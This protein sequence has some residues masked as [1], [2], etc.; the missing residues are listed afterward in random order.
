MTTNQPETEIGGN[1]S[2]SEDN[3]VLTGKSRGTADVSTEGGLHAQFIRS[4]K[5]HAR[6]SIDATAAREHDGV[7]AVYTGEEI[8][9]SDTPTP[10]RFSLYGPPMRGLEYPDEA[11]LQ[12]TVPTEK[13]HYHG[14]IIGVVVAEQRRI[15]RDAVDKVEVSYD[16]LEPIMTTRD[17]IADDAPLIHESVSDNVVFEGTIGDK[18]QTGKLFKQAAH[19]AELKKDPQRV[20]P[21][22]MEPRS[23]IAEYDPATET[24]EFTAPTQIPHA[25]RRLLSEMLA[26]PENKVHVTSPDMGGGFGSRQHPYPSDVLVGWCAIELGKPVKW[27][28]TRSENQLGETDGR[29]YDGT[30]EIAMSEDGEILSFRA[31]IRYDLGAWVARGGAGISEA[32]NASMTGLYDI[33]AVHSRIRGVVTNKARVDAYRGVT[34]TPT[35]MMLERL[36][37]KVAKKAEMDPVAVRRQNF[38]APEQFPYK[39]AAG[40]VYDSGDYERNFQLALETIDYEHITQK[41][42]ELRNEGRYLGIGIGCFI[43]GSALGPSEELDI[44]TWGYGGV[45]IHHT[46]EVTV[47]SGGSNHGQGHETSLAQVAT[48]ELG[49]PFE[50]VRVVEDSTKEVADGVGTYASRT[51]ALCGSAIVESCQKVIEKGRKVVA[52]NFDTSVEQIQFDDGLYTVTGDLDQSM[53]LDEVAELTHVGAKIPDELEP[54]LEEQTYFDPENRAWSFGTHIAVVE[55]DRETGEISFHD[56]VATEDCGVQI[57]PTIVKG[58][59]HGAIAQGLGQVLFEKVEYNDDGALVSDILRDES[60]ESSGGYTLPKAAFMPEISIETTETPSPH[61]AHGVKGAGES[62]T[63]AAPGAIIN[64]IED[65]I[66]PFSPP[67][68]LTPPIT[69]EKLWRIMNNN[70]ES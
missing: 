12:Q 20:A 33:P 54:G 45:Q 22:P 18:E 48:T 7:V 63:M 34:V 31:D 3:R 61:T 41:K 29:G 16:T 11:Y 46:G 38:V 2:R 67:D 5:A 37:T 49:V 26:H 52:H 43:E 19:T 24:L 10:N 44:A 27:R 53:R 14:E 65:A 32:G 21:T 59:A 6:Y 70:G 51:A 58:Q 56:Y 15:A 4:E 57:N 42:E 50:D 1:V 66:E 9:E 35:L 13:V 36:V 30:W 39:T 55:V 69:P 8:E 64:A 28:A 17:A 60:L 40:S 47:Y 62:G 23:T 68:S 25:Y